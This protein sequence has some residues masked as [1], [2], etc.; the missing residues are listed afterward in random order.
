MKT[1]ERITRLFRRI[2]GSTID[3]GLDSYYCQLE[4][5]NALEPEMSRASDTELKQLADTLRQVKGGLVDDRNVRFYALVREVARRTVGMRPFDVQILGALAMQ[6]GKLA[7]MQTGEGKTLAAVFRAAFYAHEGRVHVLTFND[8]LARRDAQWMEPIYRAL[9]LSVGLVQ[10]GMTTQERQQAYKSDITYL[11]AKEAGFDYLRDSLCYNVGDIVHRPFHA[12]IVDEADS[13]LID[14]AR[15]PLV[16][17]GSTEN[18][19][20]DSSHIADVACRMKAGID[21][22]FDEYERNIHLTDQGQR[23][24]ERLLNCGNLYAAKNLKTLTRLYNALHAEHL[25]RRDVDYIVRGGRIELVDE[26]TGRIADG[27]RWPDG[28]QTA[29]EAKEHINIRANGNILNQISLQHFLRLY[30]KLC[31]MTATAESSEEEFKLFYDLDIAVIPPNVPCIREDLPDVI[32]SGKTAK[33]DAIIREIADV[34]KTGR[35]ILVGTS[36]VSESAQLANSLELRGIKCQVL[37]AKHD[38]QEA[39]IIAEA[40]KTGTVTV[41][42]NMAG[43]GTDI[44]LGGSNELERQQVI[45]LGGLYVIGANK[46]ETE[47]IDKQLRGR[48]GRQGDPGTSRFFVSLQDDLMQ[49]YN[50]DDLLPATL[51]LQNEQIDNPLVRR[52]VARIQRICDG[53][54]VEI[55]KTLTKYSHLLEKQRSVLFNRRRRVLLDGKSVDFF[56]TR[57]PKQYKRLSG[58]LNS[59]DLEHVCAMITLHKIDKMWLD[60]LAQ[61]A[62]IREGIHLYRLAGRDPYLEFQKISVELFDT[63]WQ[64]MDQELLELFESLHPKRKMNPES[65]GIKAPTATWTYHINDNPLDNQLG[66]GLIGNTGLQVTAGLLGPLVALQLLIRKKRTR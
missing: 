6:D 29:I 63:L 15:I 37:N 3:Y 46:H 43:R 41:S 55:K 27:R 64:R 4:Q 10:E 57:S 33:Q 51:D 20:S 45:N 28:L 19:P 13:I 36:S 66:L 52:E 62:D 11:T 7:Q 32:F 49:K 54:N 21:F 39:G 48:A 44:R 14:E 5:I 22:E 65:L 50:L 40:G 30:P 24:A 47:R 8:Y 31:G 26:F 1:R 56:R 16:I 25:L 53:H 59:D 12:A 17:A 18:I 34:S 9:G 42:T 2:Q 23:I 38:D 35:P 60:F 61:I 58:T